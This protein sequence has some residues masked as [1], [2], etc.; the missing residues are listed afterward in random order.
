M[1]DGCM[2]R[3]RTLRLPE[4]C[5]QPAVN[6]IRLLLVLTVSVEIFS[7]QFAVLFLLLLFWP[8]RCGL[9]GL[10]PIAELHLDVDTEG[11][12]SGYARGLAMRLF[13]QMKH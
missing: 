7:K 10:V 5:T 3:E 9:F 13:T 1:V 6:L 2:G 11:V 12:F 8:W 4:L